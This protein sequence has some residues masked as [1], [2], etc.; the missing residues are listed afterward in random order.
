MTLPFRILEVSK[1]ICR[2]LDLNFE[3]CREG[4]VYRDVC[5]LLRVSIVHGRT[6]SLVSCS[7]LDR[8]RPMKEE[9]ILTFG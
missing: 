4:F 5:N 3:F 2:L 8:A 1:N 7:I 9:F 6:Q